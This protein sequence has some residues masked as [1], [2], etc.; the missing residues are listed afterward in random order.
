MK[1][2]ERPTKPRFDP[3]QAPR[4]FKNEDF[5]LVHNYKTKKVQLLPYDDVPDYCD[6]GK[7]GWSSDRLADWESNY[8]LGYGYFKLSDLLNAVK[9]A[10]L[11]ND[12]TIDSYQPYD[13]SNNVAF[14]IASSR[15]LTPDEFKAEESAYQAE[16]DRREKVLQEYELAKTNYKTNKAEYDL[17]KAQ[18][19]V[20]TLKEA[21]E[22]TVA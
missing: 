14:G 3:I 16:L 12:V 8:Y 18:Q 11:S 5:I 9:E 13:G 19:K 21:M 2:P 17:W 7:D 1:K 4:D 20:A 10:G 22:E 15:K 6:Y